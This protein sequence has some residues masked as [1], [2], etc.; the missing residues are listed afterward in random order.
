MSLITSSVWIKIYRK[1][2]NIVCRLIDAESPLVSK[3]I[4]LKQKNNNN[5]NSVHSLDNDSS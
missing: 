4:D 3:D 5:I 1:K 2:K